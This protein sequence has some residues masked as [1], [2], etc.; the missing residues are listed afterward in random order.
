MLCRYSYYRHELR[1]ALSVMSTHTGLSRN[2]VIS[3]LPYVICPMLYIIESVSSFMSKFEYKCSTAHYILPLA[4]M[5]CSV[6]ITRY[7]YSHNEFSHRLNPSVSDHHIATK[8]VLFKKNPRYRVELII[9][10]FYSQSQHTNCQPIVATFVVRELTPCDF[11]T[12]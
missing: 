11:E 9:I 2:N 6:G 12:F 5:L 4:T 1:C 3:Q 10:S 7:N 8:A